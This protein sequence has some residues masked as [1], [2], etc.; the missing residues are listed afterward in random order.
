MT[1]T[2]HLRELRLIGAAL[3]TA[4][5]LPVGAAW[6]AAAP[7]KAAGQD[8]AD[9][10]AGDTAFVDVSVATLWVKPGTARAIDKPSTTN[11][12]DLDAW[13]KSME[14]TDTRRW[15]TGKLETQAA[16]GSKV[17]VVAVD[18]KWAQ[19]A[20]ADQDTP[21]DKRGYPGWVPVRQLAEND[22]FAQQ[23]KTEDR[24]VVT[25]KKAWL[26]KTASGK[27]HVVR[28]GFNTG[29]PVLEADSS[30]VRVATPDGKKAW[31]DADA[32]TVYAQ[33]EKPAKPTGAA[34][35]RTAK[36]FLGLRYLWAGVSPWGFDCSGFTY[37]IYRSHGIAI[38]RDAG[39]QAE[40]AN[41]T[42]VDKNH[43]K[44]GDLLFFAQPGG[45]GAVHHV[46]MYI[47]GG[48]M[49]HAPNAST[50]VQIVDW[51]QWDTSDEFAGAQR[52]L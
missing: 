22:E 21:R 3:T 30:A 34:L 25:A 24:A 7:S 9:L 18:G 12:V 43:L 47:G 45:T 32:V 51:R 19:V 5:L 42:P 44:P 14:D 26:T 48:E 4:L 29:L 23:V 33:G 20:V 41:G 15:L 49:I 10:E 1:Y 50:R 11:P 36:K 46:G 13:N 35:V 6:A 16:Y 39:A 17:K 27:H 8:G 52:F 37:S 38:P 28:V 2:R 31:V 40:A